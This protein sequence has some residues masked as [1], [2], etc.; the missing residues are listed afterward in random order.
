MSTEHQQTDAGSRAG[1]NLG[2]AKT[3]GYPLDLV[4]RL[5]L[6]Q[7]DADQYAI[8]FNNPSDGICIINLQG[9]ILQANGAFCRMSGYTARELTGMSVSRLEAAQKPGEIAERIQRTLDAGGHVSFET[10]NRR[11]DGS[12]FDIDL[13]AV[14]VDRQNGRIA[15][16][17]RDITEAR[18][19]ENLLQAKSKEQQIILDAAPA[20]I[21]YKDCSNRFVRVNGEFARMMGDTCEQLEGKSSFDLYPKEQAEGFWKDDLEVIRSGCPKRG[22]I[23]YMQTPQGMRMLRTDKIPYVNEHG[24]ITGVIGFAVDITE[25]KQAEDELR[26]LNESLEQRVAERTFEV[27]RQA[28][29]MRA[30]AS[31]LS[32]SEQQERKR[33]ARILHDHVQQLLVAARMQLVP[34]RKQQHPEHRAAVQ[35]A[36]SLLNEALEIARS[37]TCELSPPVLHDRGLSAGLQWLAARMKEM[38]RFKVDFSSDDASEPAA[39]DT[40]FLV[41]ECVRELLLNVCKHSGVRQAKVRLSRVNAT[42]IQVVVS[43]RGKGFDPDLH[44]A[45]HGE[46]NFGLFSIRQRLAHAGGRVQIESA[47]GKGACFTLIIPD[48]QPPI[49]AQPDAGSPC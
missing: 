20:M 32:L 17:I 27:C 21:F 6:R 30:L 5:P 42:E 37:L 18:R 24:R 10:Q 35:A 14:G 11:K 31:Q 26:R 49:P 4:P 48:R 40:R 28:E 44:C 33:I 3:D 47:P 15:V 16:I 46:S 38:N 39:E 2:S 34:I 12:V 9:E 1:K 29:Q 19:M 43:D 45:E 25:L 8:L 36:D 41:F 13:T 7:A 22:I 23:E